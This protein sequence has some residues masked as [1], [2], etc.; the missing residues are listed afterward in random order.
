MDKL[1]KNTE[2]EVE[3]TT[4]GYKNLIFTETDSLLYADNILFTAKSLSLTQARTIFI[5]SQYIRQL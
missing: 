3:Q 2:G 1:T 5:L 4:I